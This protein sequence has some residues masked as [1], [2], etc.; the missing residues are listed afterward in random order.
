M[1][2]TVGAFDI[3]QKI[4]EVYEEKLINLLVEQTIRDK[5]PQMYIFSRFQCEEVE[6]WKQP[7][8]A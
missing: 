2:I 1:K 7:N 5:Y 8:N 3:M 4:M 6:K